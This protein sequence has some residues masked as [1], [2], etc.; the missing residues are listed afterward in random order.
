MEGKGRED[1]GWTRETDRGQAKEVKERETERERERRLHGNEARRECDG[2][3]GSRGFLSRTD[4]S[5]SLFLLPRPPR[6][7]LA[8][9]TDLFFSPTDR[10][11]STDGSAKREERK[12]ERAHNRVLDL[13]LGYAPL[14]SESFCASFLLFSCDLFLLPFSLATTIAIAMAHTRFIVPDKPEISTRWINI[15]EGRG[16]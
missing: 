9:R 5:V 16:T 8:L 14:S 2:N 15:R 10:A 11:T 1:S 13:A 12:V 4:L 3:H 6:V 7:R